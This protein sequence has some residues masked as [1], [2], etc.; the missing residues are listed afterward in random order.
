M[1]ESRFQSWPITEAA[2]LEPYLRSMGLQLPAREIDG[3]SIDEACLSDAVVTFRQKAGDGTG[4]FISANGLIL[5]NHHVVPVPENVFKD[6][7]VGKSVADEIPIPNV[8]VL[9]TRECVDI[10]NQFAEIDAELDPLKC[11]KIKEEKMKDIEQK[12]RAAA[13]GPAS[14]FDCKVQQMWPDQTYFLFVYEAIRDVRLVFAPPASMVYT[15]SRLSADFA[16]LR[17]YVAP[18][19]SAAEYS[20]DNVPYSPHKF[21]HLAHDGVSL[22]DFVFLLGFP[23]TSKRYASAMEL[24]ATEAI[25]DELVAE[26]ES[27]V[28]QQSIFGTSGERQ[29]LKALKDERIAEEDALGDARPEAKALVDRIT[30]LFQDIQDDKVDALEAELSSIS[31]QL[32]QLQKEVSTETFYP[33]F[34]KQLRLSAGKVE[35]VG[36]HLQSEFPFTNLDTAV[37]LVSILAAILSATVFYSVSDGTEAESLL[38]TALRVT[39]GILSGGASRLA[40]GMFAKKVYGLPDSVLE[41]CTKEEVATTPVTIR[42]STDVNLGNSG[43]P[44]LN[45]HGKL[46][47]LFWGG[48]PLDKYRFSKG[49]A[50]YAVDLRY[51]LLILGRYSGAEWLVKEISAS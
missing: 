17:A 40:L 38:D 14:S 35:T 11:K 49:K 48:D 45:A 30:E 51:I 10:S 5:T 26:Y 15:S 2:N 23:D 36:K 50:G 9:I 22:G 24:I 28:S 19:G 8:T 25:Y 42:Q 27:S 34:N 4:S 21:L 20:P 18:D 12:A 44:V 43:S 33:E 6:G 29:E 39:S 1:M 3:T 13:S 7:V 41:L 46:V 16:L 47:G 37:N 32:V 31:S